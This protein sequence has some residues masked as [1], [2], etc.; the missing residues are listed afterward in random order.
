MAKKKQKKKEHNKIDKSKKIQIKKHKSKKELEEKKQ[1]DK[2]SQNKEE[3]KD[4]QCIICFAEYDNLTHKERKLKC[5]H[6]LCESCFNQCYKINEKCPICRKM[7]FPKPS[8]RP[9]FNEVLKDLYSNRN[10]LFPKSY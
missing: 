3:S 9:D 7:L 10:F 1:D 4:K 6:T 8:D 5:N 2:D